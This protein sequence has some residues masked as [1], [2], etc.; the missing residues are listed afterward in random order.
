MIEYEFEKKKQA[1]VMRIKAEGA[2]LRA[3]IAIM[4]AAAA[5]ENEAKDRAARLRDS[6]YFQV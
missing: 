3:E 2:A 4:Q 6:E 5:S 1:E